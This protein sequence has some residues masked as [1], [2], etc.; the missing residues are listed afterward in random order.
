MNTPYRLTAQHRAIIHCFV[1]V[2]IAAAL[3][4]CSTGAGTPQSALQPPGG[5]TPAPPPIIATG[6][7]RFVGSVTIG[8][9]SYYGDAL[10]TLDGAVR[11][12]VGGPYVTDALIEQARPGSSAQFVGN[13]DVRNNAG[14]GSGVVIGQGC[15]A[16]DLARFCGQTATGGISIKFDYRSMQGDIRVETRQGEETWLFDLGA[17]DNWYTQPAAVENLAGNYRENLAQFT[18]GGEVIIS[19]D[20]AGQLFFQSAQTG[21]TG[22]GSL[23]AHADGQFNVYD[24]SLDIASCDAAHSGLN[25][26]FEGLATRTAS[27]YWDYD[28]LLRV[29]LSARD[30]TPSQAAVI[31]LASPIEHQRPPVCE[32]EGRSRCIPP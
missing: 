23:T 26:A 7:G 5:S 21:C 6:H 11:L 22:N 19:I 9:A 28:S 24:I 8:A 12:Y 4:G 1:G 32:I 14:S 16:G 2:L 10:I 29:W 15:D 20:G 18:E 13:L 31:M 17:W 3:A 30:G 25:G 27:G